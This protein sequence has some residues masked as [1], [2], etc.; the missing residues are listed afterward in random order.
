MT[1]LLFLIFLA[2]FLCFVSQ[3]E[4]VTV[5]PGLSTSIECHIS[6]DFPFHVFWI[7]IPVDSIPVSQTFVDVE[8]CDQFK[9]HSRIKVSWNRKTF[10]LTFSSVDPTDV[11]I[12]MCGMY[13]YGD[14]FFGNGTKLILKEHV[15]GEY[16]ISIMEKKKHVISFILSLSLSL[17]VKQR[18][19]EVNY[20]ALNFGN[21]QRRT[22][23]K[24][25]SVETTVIYG[26][27]QHQEEI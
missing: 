26:A 13:S 11:A 10:N 5:Q 27:V 17:F 2:V 9:N 20:A 6:P 4:T 23:Q 7:K 19:D 25:T 15:D 22:V 1:G 21:K 3:L 8:M 12:Y 14:L 18:T 24:R 16:E